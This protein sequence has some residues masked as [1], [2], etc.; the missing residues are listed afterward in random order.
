MT[1]DHDYEHPVRKGRATYL[2]PTC[3]ED[4]TLTLVFMQDAIDNNQP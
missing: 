1:C 3:G 2:C 4:I